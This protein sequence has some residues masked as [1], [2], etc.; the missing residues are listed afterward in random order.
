MIFRFILL[1][2]KLVLSVKHI[3][4]K[5]FVHVKHDPFKEQTSTASF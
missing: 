4:S 3:R 2:V 1:I 5:T